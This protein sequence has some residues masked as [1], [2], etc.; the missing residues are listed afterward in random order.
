M[1]VGQVFLLHFSAWI[2]P[3]ENM[4][5]RA[6]TTKFT[7]AHN[8]HATPDGVMNLSDEIS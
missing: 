5:P 7:P 1:P 6:V 4:N 8:A 2:Q 3:S